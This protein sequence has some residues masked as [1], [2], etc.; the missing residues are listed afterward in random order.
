MLMYTSSHTANS[1]SFSS[2]HTLNSHNIIF[3]FLPCKGTVVRQ[4]NIAMQFPPMRTLTMTNKFMFI[5]ICDALLLLFV[6]IGSKYQCHLIVIKFINVTEVS[7]KTQILV[8][9]PRCLWI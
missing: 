8:G 6:Q 7:Q 1:A 4:L 9:D 2:G 5:H 3:F